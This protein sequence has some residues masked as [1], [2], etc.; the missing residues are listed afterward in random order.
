MSYTLLNKEQ[1][2]VVA[3]ATTLHLRS[4]IQYRALIKPNFTVAELRQ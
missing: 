4:P 1:I 3:M 2:M